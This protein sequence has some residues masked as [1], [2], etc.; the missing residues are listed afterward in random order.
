MVAAP[1]DAA[2]AV[3][4]RD[5][6]GV[7][8]KAEVLMLKRRTDH[9]SAAG[10]H[11][12]P[13]GIVEPDDSIP[14]ALALSPFFAPEAAAARFK[15]V[16]P[17]DQALGF[18]IAALR[19]TFEET[20]ILLARLGDGTL[21]EPTRAEFAYIATNRRA[22][23]QGSVSF[24]SMMHDIERFLATDLLVYFAHWLT[25]ETRPLRFSTR[26]F[27]ARVPAVLQVQ[28]DDIE[29]AEQVWITP[30]EALRRHAAGEMEM[31]TVTAKILQTLSA[32]SST[33]AAFR[34][35]RR[36]SVEVVLPKPG[37][38]ADGTTRMLYPGDEGY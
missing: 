11:V 8:T 18:W 27:L 16:M 9:A 26:F 31:L 20:G 25:P 23:L 29:A 36:V 28:P 4:M 14:A 34:A 5:V 10:A 6:P 7:G 12:F 33:E 37:V 30:E 21:W 15:D 38:Q 3:L 1:R 13:G 32:F 2:T 35:L 19:K 24:V 17:P 22:Y